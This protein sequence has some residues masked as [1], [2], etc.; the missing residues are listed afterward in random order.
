MIE[1]K[2]HLCCC[3]FIRGY[4][5]SAILHVQVKVDDRVAESLRPVP[6]IGQGRDVERKLPILTRVIERVRSEVEQTLVREDLIRGIGVRSGPVVV[7]SRIG[8]RED[9]SPL[10]ERWQLGKDGRCRRTSAHHPIFLQGDY[11]R[12]CF[13]WLNP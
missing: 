5:A 2:L 8:H 6:R 3:R 9:H 1:I 12:H 7:A 10:H 13:P 4:V 11:E